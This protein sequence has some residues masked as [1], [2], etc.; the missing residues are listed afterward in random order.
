MT[1]PG[2]HLQWSVKHGVQHVHSDEEGRMGLWKP[3]GSCPACN[4]VD[5]TV[6]AGNAPVANGAVP[7][8]DAEAKSG[9]EARP[10]VETRM[11]GKGEA[12]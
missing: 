12:T 6:V 10:T 2:Q 1:R 4:G 7:P 5:A 8:V 9:A 3:N 11:P